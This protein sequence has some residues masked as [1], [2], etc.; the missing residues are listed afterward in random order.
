MRHL[1]EEGPVGSHISMH[2]STNI[3]HISSL[4]Q[5]T[6]TVPVALAKVRPR[7]NGGRKPVYLLASPTD[8]FTCFTTPVPKYPGEGSLGECAHSL[9]CYSTVC[10]HKTYHQVVHQV[11]TH[12]QYLC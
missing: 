1:P 4:V 8:V 11:L 6:V 5:H 9:A 10:P 7:V 3:K 2:I 12:I